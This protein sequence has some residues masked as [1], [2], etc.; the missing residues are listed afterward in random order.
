MQNAHLEA[1]DDIYVKN[2]ST[3]SSTAAN[4]TIGQRVINATLEKYGA[5]KNMKFGDAS[6]VVAQSAEGQDAT[7]TIT[8]R[9]FTEIGKISI[10]GGVLTWNANKT[11]NTPKTNNVYAA[12]FDVN[13][14]NTGDVLLLGEQPIVESDIAKTSYGTGKII[15]DLGETQS[16][17]QEASDYTG[18]RNIW[19]DEYGW[20]N[21]DTGTGEVKEIIIINPIKPSRMEGF[22][23]G[24]PEAEKLTGLS[25]IDT[26]NVT[27]LSYC[28]GSLR[29]IK[30]LDISSW[31]TSNVTNMTGMLGGLESVKDINM[32]G[33]DLSKIN[34]ASLLAMTDA[35]SKYLRESVNY[36]Y[37]YY[38]YFTGNYGDFYNSK[39]SLNFSNTILPEELSNCFFCGLDIKELDLTGADV[40]RITDMSHMFNYC[41]ALE[42]IYVNETW[43][44]D[45]VTKSTYMFSNGESNTCEKLKGGKG[46]AWTS[47]HIDKEYARID[48]PDNGKPGYFTKK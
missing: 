19:A 40:S 23:N 33:L 31:D 43:N 28:F 47:N 41:G 24:F 46:T 34:K 20:S 4:T 22:F 18:P 1:Y 11:N 45:N 42:T 17:Y 5:S 10:D 30:E 26:S 15:K 13:N 32:S 29:N 9:D 8:T 14:D 27:D 6:I 3:V 37:C 25:L 2:N 38:N 39:P 44:T 16:Q 48:D 35:T 36:D 21:Y 7:V 12:V